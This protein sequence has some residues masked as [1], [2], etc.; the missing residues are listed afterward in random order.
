MKFRQFDADFAVSA[1]KFPL[2]PFEL[3]DLRLRHAEL[4]SAVVTI[5]DICSPQ[6]FVWHSSILI[7]FCLESVNIIQ[8]RPVVI[9]V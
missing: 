8:V 7:A 2:D 3:R 1:A 6:A 4:C 9:S 5:D